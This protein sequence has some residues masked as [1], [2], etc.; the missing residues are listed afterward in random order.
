MDKTWRALGFFMGANIQVVSL[1]LFGYWIG[2]YLDEAYP[3]SWRWMY[4][5]VMVG[6]LIGLYGFYVVVRKL[7]EIER[8]E[9][10]HHSD[11]SPPKF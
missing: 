10:N 6:F 11:S 5:L 1:I 2:N 9:K 3:M 7:L 4:I 8:H